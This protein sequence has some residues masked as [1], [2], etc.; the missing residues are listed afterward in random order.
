MTVTIPVP[1]PPEEETKLRAHAKAGAS[2]SM[3]CCAS[4]TCFQT[5]IPATVFA[6]GQKS[7]WSE[8]TDQRTDRCH[9]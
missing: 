3:L 8:R 6:Q 4:I 7:A 9:R 2:P 5:K 1:L